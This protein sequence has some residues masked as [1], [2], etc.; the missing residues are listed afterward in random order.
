M[1]EGHALRGRAT[2]RDLMLRLTKDDDVER[3]VLFTNIV[4]LVMFAQSART[5]VLVEF[6]DRPQGL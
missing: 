2:A 5:S 1:A 4:N 6:I 3:Q